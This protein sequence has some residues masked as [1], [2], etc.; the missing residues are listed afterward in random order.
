[1]E[2]CRLDYITTAEQRKQWEGSE[3]IVECYRT[4][5]HKQFT[6]GKPKECDQNFL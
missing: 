4:Y 3:A 2:V 5:Q 6:K 1:M